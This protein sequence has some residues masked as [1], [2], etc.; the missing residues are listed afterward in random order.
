[1]LQGTDP[2]F[3]LKTKELEDFTMRFHLANYEILL[4]RTKSRLDHRWTVDWV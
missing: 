1:M 3:E 4:S 2:G